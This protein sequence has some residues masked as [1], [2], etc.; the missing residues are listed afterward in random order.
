MVCFY[1]RGDP[2][3]SNKILKFTVLMRAMV[4][5]SLSLFGMEQYLLAEIGFGARTVHGMF[6]FDCSISSS[7]CCL[8]EMIGVGRTVVDRD[9]L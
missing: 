3:V 1:V 6:F 9:I 2:Y 4:R 8:S 5:I 7:E